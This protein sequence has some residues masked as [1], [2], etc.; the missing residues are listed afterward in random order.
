MIMLW[1]RVDKRSVENLDEVRRPFDQIND[2]LHSFMGW[3][4]ERGMGSVTSVFWPRV[5][6]GIL[7]IN[8]LPKPGWNVPHCALLPAE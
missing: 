2:E 3:P 5:P 1:E 7:T 8:E 4:C 6:W